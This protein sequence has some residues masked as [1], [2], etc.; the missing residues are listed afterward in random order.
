MRVI[1]RV[2]SCAPWISL[3]RY[4]G[5]IWQMAKRDVL[6]RYRGSFIGL[7]WSFFYPLVLLA[8]YT[9]VFSA[10][11]KVRW[12]TGPRESM[13]TFALALFS[14]MIV[15]MLFSECL[16][17]APGLILANPNL[18][19]KVVFP[20]EILPWV[21]LGSAFFHFLV[22]FGVLLA[23]CLVL[24]H[25]LSWTVVFAPLVVVP[26]LLVSVGLM[27]FIASLGVY[28]RDMAQVMGLVTLTLNFLCPIFYPIT[29]V[30]KAYRPL[31]YLNPM[32]PLVEQM[33]NIVLW[34]R[35]PDWLQLG[36][37]TLVGLVFSYLGFIWF[38]KTKKGFADVL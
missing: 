9:F 2:V 11:L 21:T 29:E 34:G 22:S 30:P 38:Q 13:G 33:R 14:G 3:W 27:W 12:R 24:T 35:M 1:K 19:K 15:Y 4:R 26:L 10:V 16:N 5:L 28:L 17:K 20:L 23:A 18:V 31:L 7:A 6:G 37:V 8:V 25:S 32:T 36:A